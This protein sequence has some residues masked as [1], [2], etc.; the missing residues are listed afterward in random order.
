QT[1]AGDGRV[2]IRIADD[3]KGIPPERMGNLFDPGFTSTGS[4][5]RMRTGLFASYNILQKH[6]GA[7]QIESELGRGTVFTLWIPDN[8]PLPAGESDERVSRQTFSREEHARCGQ[9]VTVC[10]AR[11]ISVAR[12][13]RGN[14]IAEVL[15]AAPHI[16]TPRTQPPLSPTR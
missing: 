6:R 14:G 13:I 4:S 12:A 5:V 8:L 15:S 9:E 2:Y 3:G 7:I 11:E 10:R 1:F 16:H